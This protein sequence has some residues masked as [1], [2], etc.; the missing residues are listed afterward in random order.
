[1]YKWPQGRVIRTICLLF[2][3]A[4]TLDIFFSPGGA[5]GNLDAYFSPVSADQQPLKQLVM[6]LAFTVLAAV[7]L[8]AGLVAVGFHHKAVDFLI[9][10]EQEMVKVEWPTSN[11]LVRST[12]IIAI[13]TA[14]LAAVIVGVD[15][16]NFHLLGK[17]IPALFKQFGA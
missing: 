5:W 7:C 1:M 15:T 17:W 3:A 2:V 16:V 8:V 9:E 13:A 10:V 4:M 6:G 12:I 11:V 14:I